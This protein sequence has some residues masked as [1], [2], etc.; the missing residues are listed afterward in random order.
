M[1]QNFTFHLIVIFY[2]NKIGIWSFET[3]FS[4][5]ESF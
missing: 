2:D 1:D 3:V 4:E 5:F